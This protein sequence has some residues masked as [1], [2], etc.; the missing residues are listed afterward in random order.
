MIATVPDV[1]S[2]SQKEDLLYQLE[3]VFKPLGA[4]IMIKPQSMDIRDKG[5]D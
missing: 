4:T 1:I 2:Y 5:K 3:D